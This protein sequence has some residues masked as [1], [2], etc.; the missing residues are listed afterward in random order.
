MSYIRCLSNPESLYI[1]GETNCVQIACGQKDLLQMPTRTFHGLL[2]KF[3]SFEEQDVKYGDATLFY[4]KIGK[5][6]KWEMNY[7]TWKQPIRLWDVTLK[8]IV[9]TN[10]FKWKKKKKK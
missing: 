6:F 10:S 7:K 8:Y 9:F 2:K 1:W 5:N 4:K 3:E